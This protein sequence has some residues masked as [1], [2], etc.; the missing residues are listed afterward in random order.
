MKINWVNIV[1][2]TLIV[3]LLAWWLWILGI[4]DTQKWLLSCVGGLIMEVGLVGT[5]GFSFNN[6]RSGVQTKIVFF[7]L[8]VITF[9]ASIA[10]SFFHFSPESYCIP[11]AV[12]CLICS[13]TGV[14]IYKS[15]E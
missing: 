8:M 15:K 6:E 3:G 1:I 4:G 13:Y 12:F 2:A 14:K 11:L 10:Y 7:L 9:V 5:M